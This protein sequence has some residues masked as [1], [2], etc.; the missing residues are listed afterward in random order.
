MVFFEKTVTA[1]VAGGKPRQAAARPAFFEKKAAKTFGR[2]WLRRG[3]GRP[4]QL[5]KDGLP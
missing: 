3:R 1:R 5:K 4:G 2:F